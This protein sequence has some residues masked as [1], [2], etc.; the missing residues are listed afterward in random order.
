MLVRRHRNKIRCIK[1]RE[2]NWLTD[3]IEIK[4]HIQ[5]G[6]KKLCRTELEVIP[7]D[8][9]VSRFSCCFLEEEDR[10]RIDGEVTDGEIQ[11]GLWDFKPFKAPGPDA[12]HASFYQHFWMEVKDG[13]IQTG[14]WAFKPF[15]APGPDALHASF[16]Q[17]FWMEVKELVYKEVKGI[18]HKGCMLKFL[19]ETLISLIPKCQNPESLSNYRPISLCNSVYKVV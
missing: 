14:L 2:G 11:T 16:Y 15:K 5:D 1:D 18:F 4:N 12:L 19:N 9:N 8:S 10:T 6:F 13:E 17:H 7:I 3:E